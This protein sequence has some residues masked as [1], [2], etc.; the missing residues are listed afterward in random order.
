MQVKDAWSPSNLSGAVGT[1]AHLSPS[2][3]AFVCSRLIA[4]GPDRY[5][6]GP[7]G[8]AREST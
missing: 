6:G 4:S 2:V 1:N 5:P 7:A 3:E 8:S